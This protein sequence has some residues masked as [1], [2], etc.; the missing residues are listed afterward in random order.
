MS[1]PQLKILLDSH[2][3]IDFFVPGRSGSATATRLVRSAIEANAELLYS[4]RVLDDLFYEIRRDAAE[5]VRASSGD[6]P[7]SAARL[8][9]DYAW[10][11]I[12]DLNDIATAIGSDD[13]DL[14]TALKLRSLSED[15]DD[16]LMLAAAQR[17]SVDYLVTADRV[18]LNKATVAA[19][20]PQDMLTVL[21]M[22]L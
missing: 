20:A 19:L 18:L 9:H 1:A 13:A 21:Q 5:W 12:E 17:A 8:C 6:M 15:L 22:G 14:Q 10:G 11:C 3:W 2:V 4:S 16:N 7:K